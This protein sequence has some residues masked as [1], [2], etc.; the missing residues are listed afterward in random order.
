MGQ[1]LSSLLFSIWGAFMKKNIKGIYLFEILLFILVIIFNILKTHHAFEAI[2]IISAAFC[3]L[4]FGYIKDNAYEKSS[5]IRATVASIMAFAIIIY[6]L[7]LFTGF[8]RSNIGFNLGSLVWITLLVGSIVSSEIIRYIVAKNCTKSKK[9]LI[10]LTA[11]F[12]ILNIITQINGVPIQGRWAVFVLISTIIIP[13]IARELLC[14][15]IAYKC[16][17]VPNIIWRFCS[18]VAIYLLPIMP[19]LGDYLA[20]VAKIL[21]PATIYF[22]SSKIFKYHE[23][24]GV[25]AKKASR[26]VIL[27]PLV[28]F[29]LVMIYLVSGLFKYKMIAIA[30]G[31]MEPVFYKGDAVIY[32][33]AE[34]H[35]LQVGDVLA[36]NHGHRI[37]THRIMSIIRNDN[38]KYDIVTKGDNNNT[39]DE[40]IVQKD[41]VLGVVKCSVKYVGYPTLWIN[42]L[43]EK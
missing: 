36:F 27:V 30:S 35:E 10:M 3:Y 18:E 40:Y 7:G 38:D 8:F 19:N 9:P 2:L 41:D 32:V 28:L 21:L 6:A 15:Y 29:A 13:I 4:K 34:A 5:V 20:A 26:R 24:S 22:L 39:K 11:E 43:I 25:Y 17:P 16:S 1:S 12:I 42:S 23:K 37:T 33:K 31:S 14:S